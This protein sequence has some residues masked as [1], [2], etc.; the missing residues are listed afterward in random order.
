MVEVTGTFILG[1]SFHEA[2]LVGAVTFPEGVTPEVVR[3]DFG[4]THTLMFLKYDV[5][6]MYLLL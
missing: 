4:F 3:G 1:G 5:C 6:M 2:L